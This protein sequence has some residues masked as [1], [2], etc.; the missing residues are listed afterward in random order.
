[1][2]GLGLGVAVGTGVA[3]GGIGVIE[4]VEVEGSGD[5]VWVGLGV[6]VGGTGVGVSVGG[7]RGVSVHVGVDVGL[8][9]GVGVG[10]GEAVLPADW[11]GARVD[12]IVDCRP[13]PR[14]PP[15]TKVVNAKPSQRRSQSRFRISTIDPIPLPHG[16]QPFSHHC[17]ARHDGAGGVDDRCLC[18]R[19]RSH[20]SA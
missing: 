17:P 18:G 1:V 15:I 14:Q 7:G 11:V 12:R 3:V 20:R 4:A 16:V 9:V 2:G 8:A 6:S 19:L 13:S 10:D 5:D